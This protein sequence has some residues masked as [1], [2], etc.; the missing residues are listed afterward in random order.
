MRP[1]FKLYECTGKAAGQGKYWSRIERAGVVDTEKTIEDAV[2]FMGTR[3]SPHMVETVVAGVIESMI[4]GTIA[5]GMTR[6][7][8]DY[9][10][11]ELDLKGAFDDKDAQFDPKKHAIKVN[12]RPLKRFREVA[13]T[14]TPENKKKPPRAYIERIGN[15]TGE[16]GQIKPGE[17]IIVTGRNLKLVDAAWEVMHFDY[18]DAKGT[19]C[20]FSIGIPELAENTSER[21]VIPGKAFWRMIDRDLGPDKSIGASIYSAGGKPDGQRR[22]VKYAKRLQIV[23]EQ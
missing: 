10:A 4:A 11:I 18:W 5:D 15:A 17:D 21:L 12:L 20:G 1:K 22:T 7:F 13:K 6:R 16:E 19:R 2:E 3:F 8:R 9:F 14:E 23:S